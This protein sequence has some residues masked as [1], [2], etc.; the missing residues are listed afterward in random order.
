MTCSWREWMPAPR[1]KTL[2]VSVTSIAAFAKCS[3]HAAVS[4]FRLHDEMR[5]LL[6]KLPTRQGAA[7]CFTL[8]RP[9]ATAKEPST[10][11]DQL[12]AST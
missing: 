7:H 1:L 8:L 12:A 4:P 2:C 3:S 5:Q 11:C 9:A 6:G 10:K